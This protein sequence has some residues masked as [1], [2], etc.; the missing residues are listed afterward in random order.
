MKIKYVKIFGERNSGTTYLYKLL[1]NN[2]IDVKLCNVGYDGGTGWKHGVPKMEL[3]NEEE[4]FL[5]IFIVR[6]LESWL[7]SMYKNQYNLKNIEKIEDFLIKKLESDDVRTLHDMNVNKEIEEQD[8]MSLRY[9]KLRS[10][11]DF[12]EKISNGIFINMT[13]LQENEKNFVKFLMKE[14]GL[15]IR[16]KFRGVKAHTKNRKIG[17]KNRV[18]DVKLPLVLI[19]RD[20][21]LENEVEKLKV[22]IKYKNGSKI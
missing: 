22:E 21:E 17:E 7:K 18:Y 14:Y 10:L 6:D 4:E 13:Y 12:Y 20:E 1:E 5:F 16:N 8:V 2:L 19:R 15:G 9:S 11:L 3:F